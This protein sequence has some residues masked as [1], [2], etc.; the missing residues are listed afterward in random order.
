M[1]FRYSALTFN[2]DRIH[3]DRSYRLEAE[4][5]PGLVVHGP[6]QATY[7]LQRAIDKKGWPTSFAFRGQTPL[8]DGGISTE[9]RVDG[10]EDP[11]LV[12]CRASPL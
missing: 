4:H 1:L 12:T 5:Y 3:Y 7:L 10:A 11:G 6:L 2:A 9:G 8:S